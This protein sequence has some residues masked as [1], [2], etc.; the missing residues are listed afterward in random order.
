MNISTQ[1]DARFFDQHVM[2]YYDAE[3]LHNAALHDEHVVDW[4]YL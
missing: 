2:D 1:E 3:D 4:A